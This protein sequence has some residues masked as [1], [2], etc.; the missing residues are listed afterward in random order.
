MTAVPVLETEFSG[1]PLRGRGK[2]RDIYDLGAH[3]LIVATDRVSAFDVVMPTPI[4]D[5][6]KILTRIAA[7]WFRKL[8]EVVDN[9]L[10]STEVGEFPKE[11]QPY[12]G[13]L[14][15]RSMLV[16]KAEPLPVECIV[17]GY[18]AGSG[19]KEYRDSGTVCGIDVGEGLLESSRLASPIFT[20]STKAERGAHDENI[21]FATLRK[22]VGAQLAE[23]L[24]DL[25]LTLYEKGAAH[26]AERGIIV[27]DT[28]FEFGV[29]A[30]KL[31]LIDEV[32]TPDS[33]RFWPVEHY[34]A[35][36]SQ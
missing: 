36:R 4:P 9:H 29:A 2:V 10:V 28:K 18:L 23:Q 26:A 24:R 34:Q 8:A 16:R 21:D 1:L 12:A 27:A 13:E 35:G 14:A 19:W 7:F 11:C 5:K 3:W 6:G 33:S 15:E 30:G 31:M 25:S 32:L 17:R 22:V 20:P